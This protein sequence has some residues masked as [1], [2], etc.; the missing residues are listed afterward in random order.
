MKKFMVMEGYIRATYRDEITMEETEELIPRY[1]F[2]IM[3]DS[4]STAEKICEVMAT[5]D[6]TSIIEVDEVDEEDDIG[7]LDFLEAHNLN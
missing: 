6:S 1:S 5:M 2:D 7:P 3:A 4:L